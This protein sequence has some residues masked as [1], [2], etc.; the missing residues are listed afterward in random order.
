MV[1]IDRGTMPIRRSDPEQTN[2]EGKM[3][4]YLTAHAAKQHERQFG[5]KNFRLLTVTTNRQRM[6]TMQMALQGIHVPRSAGPAL[7]LFATFA[8]LNATTP[9]AYDWLDGTGRTAA[10]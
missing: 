1:D 5:W 7:F 3:R 6:R 9:I 8:E 10:L 4:V 2:F